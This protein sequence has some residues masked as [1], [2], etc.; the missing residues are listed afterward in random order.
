MA[1][2]QKFSSEN[3]ARV[4]RRQW[5]SCAAVLTQ[6]VRGARLLR[7]RLRAQHDS[8]SREEV[9]STV[10]EGEAPGFASTIR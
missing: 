2:T 6:S 4:S 5:F 9:R 7:P 3:Y 8:P 10:G 1:E